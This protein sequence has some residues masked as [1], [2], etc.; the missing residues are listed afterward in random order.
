MIGLDP[1][2]KVAWYFKAQILRARGDDEEALRAFDNALKADPSYSVALDGKNEIE[3]VLQSKKIDEYSKKIL[4]YEYENKKQIK[5]KDA[6]KKF[7]IPLAILDEVYENI[8]TEEYADLETMSSDLKLRLETIS[9]FIINK[10]L[11]KNKNLQLDNITFASILGTDPSLT[12]KDAKL[13]KSY[14]YMCYS[15]N[16]EPDLKDPELESLLKKVKLDSP[17]ENIF[18][19][20]KNLDIG[21]L[22]ARTVQI[23]LSRFKD[24]EKKEIKEEKKEVKTDKGDLYL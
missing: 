23:A 6:F 19:I 7:E 15:L 1:G 16:I 13:L 18:Y 3:K 22:K 10:M 21:I 14:I 12:L 24:E 8:K 11:E 4:L 5:K 2:N 9:N 17:P 20:V